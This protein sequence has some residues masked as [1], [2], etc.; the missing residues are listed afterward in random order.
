MLL[1]AWNFFDL[2][3]VNLELE[4][5]CYSLLLIDSTLVARYLRYF[6]VQRPARSLVS[7]SLI[8]TRWQ[9]FHPIVATWFTFS[10]SA[11]TV[12]SS[13]GTQTKWNKCK[14]R[15]NLLCC[16]SAT[17]FSPATSLSPRQRNRPLTW[18]IRPGNISRSPGVI[19][20][21]YFL[22][23]YSRYGEQP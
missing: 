3:F 12:V 20:L 4:S 21:S 8:S 18:N 1:L 17:V 23:R 9:F 11:S 15:S 13:K 7:E 5:R 19:I 2:Y 22:G 6:A 16:L 14:F 10:C